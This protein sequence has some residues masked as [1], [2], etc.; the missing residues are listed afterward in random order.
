MSFFFFEIWKLEELKQYKYYFRIDSD[1]Y[2]QSKINFDLFELMKIENLTLAYSFI[3]QD[4][5]CTLKIDA[6]VRKYFEKFKNI[7]KK[8]ILNKKSFTNGNM[9]VITRYLYNSNF[10]IVNMDFFRN[11]VEF[12][13]FQDEVE[14]SNG[15]FEYRCGDHILKTLFIHMYANENDL[16]CI[17]DLINV[18]HIESVSSCSKVTIHW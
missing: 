6:L 14:K 10:E 9:D 8:I 4:N 15:I 16:K 2:I 7:G 12:K 17:G 13:N 1:A 3:E 18:I 5:R 11:S